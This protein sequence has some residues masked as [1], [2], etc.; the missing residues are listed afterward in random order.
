MSH[1]SS[2]L[3]AFNYFGGKLTWTDWLYR[4]FPE[5]V[6]FID[7]FGGSMAVTLNKKPSIINTYND[8][9]G[10]VV[11]FFRV[12]RDYPRE[13][14]T[15][16]LLTPISRQEYNECWDDVE[17]P[18]ERARRFYVRVRQSIYSMGGQQKNKGWRLSKAKTDVWGGEVVS[19]WW[20]SIPKLIEITE[21]LMGLQIENKCYSQLIPSLDFA[22]AFFYLDPPYP[23]ESRAS[24]NDYRFDFT[25]NDHIDLAD[26]AH[27]AVGK[28]MISSYDCG[29]IRELY[30]DWEIVAFPSKKN[31]IRSGLVQECIWMNYEPKGQLTLFNN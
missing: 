20:N 29:L 1:D 12:L 26:V 4:N 27:A 14:I 10:D 24:K 17:E 13:L 21:L 19:L 5:H 11:N 30:G 7:V 9:N 18:I 15:Q 22:D 25:D 6:H 2:K 8:I 31:N 16:L 3:I 23:N 28:V